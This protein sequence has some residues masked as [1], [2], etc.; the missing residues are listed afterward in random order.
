MPDQLGD[1]PVDHVDG[2]READ[3]GKGVTWP[4]DRVRNFDRIQRKEIPSGGAVDDRGW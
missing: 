1:D 2:Y 4:E 3:P